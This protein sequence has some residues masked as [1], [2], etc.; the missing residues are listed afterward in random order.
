MKFPEAGEVGDRRTLVATWKRVICATSGSPT[1]VAGVSVSVRVLFGPTG[2]G[3]TNVLGALAS[4]GERVL[5]LEALATHR[6]SAFGHAGL[7]PQPDQPRFERA[8]RAILSDAANEVLWIEHE[9]PYL[10]RLAIPRAI[11]AAMSHAPAVALRL[12]TSGRVDRIVALLAD[13]SD[14][15]IRASLDRVRPRLGPARSAAA[16]AAIA[17]G[18]RAHF[19]RVLLPYYDR[20]YAYQSARR[21]GAIVGE[22]DVSGRTAEEVA[23]RAIEIFR[24]RP[25]HR[26]VRFVEDRG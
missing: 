24:R 21:M 6:G 26:R 9:G 23:C 22:I 17:R 19:V 2:V 13:A 15:S 16:A 20:A 3:K 11:N 12:D 25:T 18:D 4:L 14:A 5:D 1:P 10:G 8:L 7:P